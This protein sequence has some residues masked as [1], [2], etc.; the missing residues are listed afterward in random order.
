ME[1]D[2]IMPLYTAAT[3]IEFGPFFQRLESVFL[4]IWIFGFCCYLSIVQNFAIHTFKKITNIKNA[5]IMVYPFGGIMLAISLIPKNY[6]I[7]KFYEKNIFP[8]LVILIVFILGLT[9]LFLANIKRKN[10]K[11]EVIKNE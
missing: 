11:N 8:S 2:D 9:V 3:Y 1:K 6:A 7:S 5:K 4:L 10:N